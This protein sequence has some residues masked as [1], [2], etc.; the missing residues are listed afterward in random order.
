MYVC[1]MYST[2]SIHWKSIYYNHHYFYSIWFYSKPVIDK[3]IKF[4]IESLNLWIY[5]TCTVCKISKQIQNVHQSRTLL[6][7]RFTNKYK[8]NLNFSAT[9]QDNSVFSNSITFK[10]ERVDWRCGSPLY[11]L[12]IAPPDIAL[13]QYHASENLINRKH[14]RFRRIQILS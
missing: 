3:K 7:E 8:K 6:L 2:H 1:N 14:L 4:Y 12:Q 9:Q 11:L 13:R 10:N 5:L